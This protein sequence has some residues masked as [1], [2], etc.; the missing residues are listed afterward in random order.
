[1]RSDVERWLARRS[2]AAK[3][4]AVADLVAAKRGE[5]VSVV[6]PALNEER[7]VGGIV[8]VIRRDLV[9]AVPLVD[10][11]VVVDSGSTDRTIQVARAAGAQV[12]Q[13]RHVLPAAGHLAGKGEVL[14]KSLHVT[15]GDLVVFIDADLRT[16]ASSFLTGLLGPLLTEP[17][18]GFVKATHDRAL[19]TSEGIALTGG[20]RVTELVARPLLNAFWPQLSGFVQPLSGQC[21][22]RR[23]LLEQV[24][25]VSGYGVETGLLIDLLGLAGLNALGQV[26]LGWLSHAHQSDHAL[27]RMAAQVLQTVLTRLSGRPAASDE[28][29]QF[30]RAASGAYEPVSWD[31]SVQQRPPMVQIP[32][33]RE[34]RVTDRRTDGGRSV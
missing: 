32:A 34:A 9:E 4:F 25:F 27:G 12:V 10:E 31:V 28:L 30:F 1:M 2:Y 22:G 8:E 24:P 19:A 6:L 17:G 11:L 13:A 33:Y 29:V 5:R 26:D 15:S 21:A 18:V 3:Q 20:G 7:T 16:F 14:W 23:E